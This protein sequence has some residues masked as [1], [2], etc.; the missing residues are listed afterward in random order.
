MR[1]VM[2]GARFVYVHRELRD[3]LRSAKAAG[4]VA[5][6]RGV[7]EFCRAWA[8]NLAGVFS[9]SRPDTLLLGY[10]EL[11]ARPGPAVERL[12]AFTGAGGIDV[13]VLERKVNTVDESAP[14]RAG[15]RL[16]PA[17]LSDQE[18]AVVERWAGNLRQQRLAAAGAAR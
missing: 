1:T 16:A 9:E 12:V 11:V 2:P 14:G 6:G 15:G 7:D 13:G 4:V 3:T 18:E 10:E 5:G 8:E 17:E